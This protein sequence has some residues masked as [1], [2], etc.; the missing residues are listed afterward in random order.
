[1]SNNHN[2]WKEDVLKIADN[3]AGEGQRLISFASGLR[4]AVAEEIDQ[5]TCL[6]LV[7]AFL[8]RSIEEAGLRTKEDA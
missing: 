1:M 4:K 3:F 6:A 5:D 7:A 8:E 2:Q